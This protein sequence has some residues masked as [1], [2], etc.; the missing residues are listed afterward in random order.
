MGDIYHEIK[1]TVDKLAK[2]HH[3]KKEV[4]RQERENN[5][6]SGTDENAGWKKIL[7]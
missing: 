5:S 6:P 1:A 7:R 4:K 3:H 2:S